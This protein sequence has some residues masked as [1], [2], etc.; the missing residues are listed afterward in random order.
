MNATDL[1][2][3]IATTLRSVVGPAVTD[4]TAK[5][6]AFMASVILRKVARELA[7]RDGSGA[8]DT[9]GYVTVVNELSPLLDESMDPTLSDALDLYSIDRS[10][11]A[12]GALIKALH[13][14]PSREADRALATIRVVLRERL[15]RELEYAR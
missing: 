6:Q 7:S 3:R 14:T 1:L 5:T 15:D 8:H 13:Q 10:D 12:L 2:E 9:R 4:E 11:V